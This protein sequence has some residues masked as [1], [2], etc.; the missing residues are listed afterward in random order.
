MSKKEEIMY[1]TLELEAE[2]GLKMRVE[3]FTEYEE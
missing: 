2:Y 3:R 1:A